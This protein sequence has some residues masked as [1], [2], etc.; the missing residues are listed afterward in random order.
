MAAKDG[1]G[2]GLCPFQVQAIVR[3]IW[4]ALALSL[5]V[6]WT[7]APA[8][9][10]AETLPPPEGEIV[11]TVTGAIGEPNLGQA[12][13][14]DLELL[15][16]LGP[17]TIRTSTLWTDGVQEFT[18]VSLRK[19]LDRVE[20]RGSVVIASAL[21]DY[22]TEIPMEDVVEGG[23]IL[24]YAQNGMPLSVR[25]KGPLWVVFPYDSDS[26]WRREV[27]Y[28]RSIWQVTRL[29]ILP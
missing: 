5:A 9:G 28:A 17:E 8:S 16:E 21:N 10:A 15:T 26:R 29:E 6:L 20:A 19:V 23:P 7:T 2:L 12:A 22:V 1:Q 27:I 3:P 24:A 14:F 25:D 18:G 11:L 13:T 4:Q